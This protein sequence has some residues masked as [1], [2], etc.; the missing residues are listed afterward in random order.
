MLI[1]RTQT[2]VG[3][4][5]LH[6]TE[7]EAAASARAVV[8]LF[9]RWRIDDDQACQLLGGMLSRTWNRWKEGEPG[10]I[11]RDLAAR[12]SLLRGMHTALRTA[13]GSDLASVYAWVRIPTLPLA[14]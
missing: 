12:L 14:A 4:N 2:K 3:P 7:A 11:D 5:V 13:F 1:E 8:N 6:L 9:V 10:R